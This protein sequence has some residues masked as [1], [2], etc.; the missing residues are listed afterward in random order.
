MIPE[1]RRLFMTLMVRSAITV[2]CVALLFAAGCSSYK[3]D[4]ENAKAE[5]VK[6][7]A[8]RDRLTAQVSKVQDEKTKLAGELKELQKGCVKLEARAVQ[9]EKA[10]SR[11]TKEKDS[12]EK[13][14]RELRREVADLKKKN[15]ELDRKLKR[16]SA[17]TPVAPPETMARRAPPMASPAEKRVLAES[18]APLGPPRESPPGQ[19][20]TPCD[21]IIEFMQKTQG[22]IRQFKGEQ[23]ASLLK[24]LKDEYEKQASGAPKRAWKSALEWAG[25]L[26]KAWDKTGGGDFVYV[27]LTKRNEVLKACNKKPEEAG[28]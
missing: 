17:L 5:I 3:A 16:E 9:A 11:L 1:R 8:E 25:E 6:L 14:S 20:R 19:S 15:E 2:L 18:K 12:V 24:K 23:R 4:L 7:K 26:S 27:L 28:F 13:K 10:K 21:S 22:V